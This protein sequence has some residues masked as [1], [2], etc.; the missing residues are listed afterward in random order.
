MGQNREPRNKPMI[1][2]SIHF[3][4]RRQEKAMEKKVSSTSVIRKTGQGHLKE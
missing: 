4:I 3:Q 2:Y 1:K